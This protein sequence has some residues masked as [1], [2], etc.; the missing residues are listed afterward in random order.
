[1]T[2]FLTALISSHPAPEPPQ[3]TPGRQVWVPSHLPWWPPSPPVPELLTA[4]E[5]ASVNR[6]SQP[7]IHLVIKDPFS[8]FP[9]FLLSHIFIRIDSVS[10]YASIYIYIF[11]MNI[12]YNVFLDNFFHPIV[13]STTRSTKLH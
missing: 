8:F 10:T 7:S 12:L 5:V 11:I 9:L 6:Q 2:Y 3:A 1:M 13:V 4:A